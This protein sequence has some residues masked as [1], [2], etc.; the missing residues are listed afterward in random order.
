MNKLKGLLLTFVKPLVLSHVS[1]LDMLAPL[2]SKKMLEKGHM[3]QEQ[4]D[5]L[6]KDL[7]DVVQ[8]ELVVLINKI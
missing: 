2:L 1:D 6:S 3:T 7:V 4:A 5:A 8:A